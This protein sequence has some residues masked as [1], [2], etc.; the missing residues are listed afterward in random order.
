M[1]NGSGGDTLLKRKQMLM[2]IGQATGIQYSCA[3]EMRE[4]KKEK[5]L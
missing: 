4:E 2:S 5:D 1:R 3:T